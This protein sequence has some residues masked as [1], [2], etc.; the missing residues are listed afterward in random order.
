MKS[1]NHLSISGVVAGLRMVP[2]RTDLSFTLVHNYG[3]GRQPLF[4]K[5]YASKKILSNCYLKKGDNI[6]VE[7]CILPGNNQPIASIK[8]LKQVTL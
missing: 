6:A 1:L 3:G 4:L 8:T 5:C 7:A 2:E